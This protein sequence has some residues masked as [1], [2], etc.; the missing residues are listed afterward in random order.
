MLRGPKG[1]K[2]QPLASDC[3]QQCKVAST[4]AKDES[5][6]VLRWQNGQARKN[7]LSTL[8]SVLV[9]RLSK[10]R[11]I[12]RSEDLCPLE[13]WFWPS[14]DTMLMCRKRI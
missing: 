8:A 7:N 13:G 2:K 1:I 10:A 6:K 3:Y 9:A 5:Q 4:K 11:Q 14:R 12:F